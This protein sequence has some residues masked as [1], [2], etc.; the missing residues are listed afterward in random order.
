[1]Q[2]QAT[3]HHTPAHLFIQAAFW[4]ILSTLIS[5]MNDAIMRI[6]GS[7][8][9]SLEIV[10]FRFFFGTLTLLP[11]MLYIGKAAFK[12][13]GWSVHIIRGTLFY[14]AIACWC[15]AITSEGIRLTLVT[16]MT[17]TIPIFILILARIFLKEKVT[18]SRFFA[19]LLGLSGIVVSFS[20][21]NLMALALLVSVIIFAGLDVINK[22][23]VSKESTFVLIFYSSLVTT[24]VGA[25]PMFFVWEMPS[26]QEL[27]FLF[28]LG[29]GGNFVIYCILKAFA[30]APVS[31]LGPFR[32]IEFVFS[33]IFGYVLFNEF[34]QEET[35]IGCAII[36]PATLYLGY[37]ESRRSR[38]MR[39]AT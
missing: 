14:I 23:L 6:M 36:I 11:F 17:F 26:P 28:I 22:V 33:A 29:I 19:A 5:S 27:G 12:P 16:A 1:M 7:E 8:L 31:A 25:I 20:D 38:K 4:F 18:K 35:L 13:N 24:V 34:P 10:W 37:S 2:H 32:Y 3:A 15:L 21:V 9:H 30:L 39:K